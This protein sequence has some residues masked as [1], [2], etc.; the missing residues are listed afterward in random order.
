MGIRAINKEKVVQ[1]S[2][3]TEI[4]IGVNPDVWDMAVIRA[5]DSLIELKASCYAELCVEVAKV[6]LQLPE[7]NSN[8]STAGLLS[9]K[10]HGR[11]AGHGGQQQCWR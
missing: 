7:N 6:S 8:R 9:G 10:R 11:R 3:I 2:A 5:F 4:F 1:I